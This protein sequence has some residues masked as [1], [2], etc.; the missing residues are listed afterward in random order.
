MGQFWREL[1]SRALPREYTHTHKRDAQTFAH[2]QHY[3]IQACTVTPSI[4]CITSSSSYNN[5]FT[6]EAA[7]IDI[8]LH[9]STFLLNTLLHVTTC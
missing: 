4:R 6:I 8:Y 9:V 1:V 3:S 2:K 5:I 7:S